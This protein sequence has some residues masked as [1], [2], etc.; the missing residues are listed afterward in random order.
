MDVLIEISSVVTFFKTEHKQKRLY[1]KDLGHLIKVVIE[2]NPFIKVI[3]FL[4]TDKSIAEC[5]KE[6][7]HSFK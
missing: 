4:G 7:L 3:L 6:E 1:I 5:I 2:K